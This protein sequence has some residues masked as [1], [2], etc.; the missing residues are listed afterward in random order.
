M[1][2][3]TSG[4]LK[5]VLLITA[6]FCFAGVS[7][8]AQREER[9][10][11]D[12]GLSCDDNWGDRDGR[13]S[14]CEMKE[15]TIAATGSRISVDGRQN[16]GV[17]VRGWERNEI[18]VRAR[19]QTWAPTESEAESIAR[20]I[21]IQ[22]A[23]A[24]IRAEGP[25]NER[26]RNWSVSF[27]VF[28]PRQSDL[29]LKAHNGGI[30]VATVRGRIEFETVNG[31]VSLRE[32]GGDVKGETT[33]GGLSIKLAGNRWDGEGLDVRTT[34]GGVNL[35]VPENYS[36]HLE[37]STVNGGLNI[38]FPVTLQGKIERELSVD[39]GSGGSPLRVRTTNGGISIK[40]G[41]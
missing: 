14:H 39:L 8:F 19:I 36:A 9:N 32:V 35:S 22:T 27:E 21:Q 24:Q 12:R 2:M 11:E 41:A 28:V 23:G 18:F 15:Q 29:S 40:R 38:G 16:G 4:L 5:A 31:G 33:N 20:Q 34:N 26:D 25:S 10:R 17:S 37:T 7:V 6:V 30:S 13:R 1:R 3:T